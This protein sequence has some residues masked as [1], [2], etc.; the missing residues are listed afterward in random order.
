MGL[1]KNIFRKWNGTSG[2]KE[3]KGNGYI[4]SS[5][6][7]NYSL[8]IENNISSS[9]L[10]WSSIYKKEDW[11]S[12]W[13]G[14][15]IFALSLPSY[16]GVYTLGW[17]PVAKPWTDITHALSTKVSDPWVGLV[18]SFIFLVFMMLP[19]NRFNGVKSK[20]WFN[21]FFIIFFSSWIIWL[22]SIFSHCK[23]HWKCKS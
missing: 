8:P 2:L 11:W 19:V 1:F 3:E 12:V 9:K 23:S 16:F 5:D 4:H 15:G 21:G 6:Q 7:N 22:L 18:T 10:N 17:I 13:I 20:D 14:L